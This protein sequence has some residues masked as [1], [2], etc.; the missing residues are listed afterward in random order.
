MG[1]SGCRLS[2]LAFCVIGVVLSS[3][4]VAWAV[5]PTNDVMDKHVELACHREIKIR[6]PLGH[7]DI[8]TIVYRQEGSLIGVARG[9]VRTQASR[10][11]WSEVYWTC[12]VDHRK[13]R[14]LRVEFSRS[15]GSSRLLAAAAAF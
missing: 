12:R 10:N 9:S 7:R 1:R 5:G 14:V 6:T 8:Q 13:G 3:I 4:A 11:N 2:V 15:T